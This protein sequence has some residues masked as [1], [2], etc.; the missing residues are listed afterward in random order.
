MQYHY[1]CTESA[2]V[3]PVSNSWD[4]GTIGNYWSETL[5]KDTFILMKITSITNPLTQAHKQTKC[6]FILP[7]AVT[8]LAASIVISLMLYNRKKKPLNLKKRTIKS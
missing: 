7:T 8:I 2:T 1:G 5:D 3:K 4:N 6:R